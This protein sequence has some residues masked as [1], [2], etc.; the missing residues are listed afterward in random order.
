MNLTCD[1]LVDLLVDYLDG[2]LTTE[3]TEAIR[4]HICG[5]GSCGNY[6]M[7]YQLTIRITRTLPKCEAPLPADCE[8]RLRTRLGL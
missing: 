3:Q 1:E 5:C 4:T 8:A 6:V 2:A 7:S